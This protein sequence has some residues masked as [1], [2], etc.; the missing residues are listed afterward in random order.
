M[1]DGREALVEIESLEI[2]SH[3]IT[4]REIKD[5]LVWAVGNR[6]MLIVKFKEYNP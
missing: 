4:Q 2:H 6:E 3:G 1:N 5:P